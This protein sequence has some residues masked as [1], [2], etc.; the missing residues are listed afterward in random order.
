MHSFTYKSA[1]SLTAKNMNAHNMNY[2]H[3]CSA[4]EYSEYKC[5]SLQQTTSRE[6]DDSVICSDNNDIPFGEN[7]SYDNDEEM[8]KKEE[9]DDFMMCKNLSPNLMSLFQTP[10][11]DAKGALQSTQLKKQLSWQAPV[12]PGL[13]PDS[14]IIPS[15][16]M[17]NRVGNRMEIGKM[18]EF[19][20]M[21]TIVY[22]IKNN[23]PLNRFQ[24]QYMSSIKNEK[25]FMHM[26]HVYEGK[27]EEEKHPPP[28]PPT[29]DSAH[30]LYYYSPKR[31]HK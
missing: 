10:S 25:D 31:I 17:Q 19:D 26:V 5:K 1:S 15:Q 30:K 23:I 11:K 6:D 14:E 27:L 18:V 2:N 9:N 24:Q 13:G 4:N 29:S 22:N 3:T 12:T 28:A 7:D 16:Y 8:Y 21:D 20:F